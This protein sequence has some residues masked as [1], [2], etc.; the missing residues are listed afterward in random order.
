ME[1]RRDDTLPLRRADTL[2]TLAKASPAAHRWLLRRLRLLDKACC[3][4]DDA[5]I[6]HHGAR[7]VA[8]WRAAAVRIAGKGYFQRAS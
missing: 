4:D 2:V 1:N 5:A 7:L 6:Q 8:G 3:R